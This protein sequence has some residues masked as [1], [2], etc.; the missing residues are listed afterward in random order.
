M[1]RCGIHPTRLTRNDAPDDARDEKD[2]EGTGGEG[3]AP[4]PLEEACVWLWLSVWSAKRCEGCREWRGH[5]GFKHQALV[6]KYLVIS[7]ANT[8]STIVGC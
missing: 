6:C 5:S 2:R 8:V 1:K 4:C 3:T 7:N